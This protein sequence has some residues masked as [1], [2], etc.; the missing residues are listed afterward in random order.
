M[1]SLEIETRPE[2]MDE[3]VH[4]L[5]DIPPERI[6]TH[7]APGTAT[8]EDLLTLPGEQTKCV[9]L[10]H[11]VLVKKPVGHYESALTMCLALELGIFLKTTK[12]G[13]ISG[14]D[15]TIQVAPGDTRCPDISIYLFDSLP[16]DFDPDVR[17][18]K[19]APDLTIEILS[20]SNTRREMQEKLGV[21][22]DNGVRSVW[23]I[24][25]SSKTAK[26]HRSQEDFSVIEEDGFLEDPDILPG[27]R[28]S[29]HSIFANLHR[30]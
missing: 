16:K 28:I 15:D 9:E 25:P 21:Y 29:L 26:L 1:G 4:R 17:I 3:L 30:P 6:R 13:Y 27:L 2:T 23:L 24:D 10:I 7:P 20:H 5:G 12:L 11:G 22:F 18:C 19:H 8:Q 14:P